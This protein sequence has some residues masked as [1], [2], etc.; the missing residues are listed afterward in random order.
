VRNVGGY[1]LTHCGPTGI[2]SS[3]FIINH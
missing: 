1:F 3:I 2:L